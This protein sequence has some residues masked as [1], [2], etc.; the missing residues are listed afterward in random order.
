MLSNW[1]VIWPLPVSIGRLDDRR[2]IKLAVQDNGQ[3]LVDVLAGDFGEALGALG[4]EGEVNFRLAQVAAHHHGAL[5]AAAVH[6]RAL[7]DL[8]LFHAFLAIAHPL[9]ALEDLIAG[10]DD[11]VFDVLIAGRTDQAEFQ[12]GRLLN[13][14][15]W[16][17]PGRR[18]TNRAVGPECGHSPPA[19]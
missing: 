15:F 12:E 13:G 5:D 18:P 19:G 7:L 4:I 6:L 14:R 2:R 9:L 16:R 8:D 11:A 1:P 17:S 3:A 10:L